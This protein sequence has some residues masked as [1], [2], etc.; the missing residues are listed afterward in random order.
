[1]ATRGTLARWARPPPLL[2]WARLSRSLWCATPRVKSRRCVRLQRGGSTQLVPNEACALAFMR[3]QRL[4]ELSFV[5]CPFRS[6]ALERPES[7]PHSPEC[8]PPKPPKPLALQPKN[9]KVPSTAQKN[10]VCMF[11]QI[12]MYVCMCIYIY[13]L[14]YMYICK[15]NLKK[16]TEP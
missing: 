15:K 5:F 3:H 13:V 7:P 6:C 1:M 8:Y 14:T 11:R 4:L 16:K 10:C 9:P 12:C 2:D